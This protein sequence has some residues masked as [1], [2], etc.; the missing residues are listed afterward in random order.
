MKTKEN[1]LE[2]I[3]EIRK[4]MEG[5][6]RFL[7]L[8]GLSGVLVGIYAL[9]GAFMANSLLFSSGLFAWLNG[10]SLVSDLFILGSIVFGLSLLTIILL[11]FIRVKKSGK[12]FWNAGSRLMLVNLSIPIVSGGLLILVLV[13]REIYE[14]IIPGTLLFYGLA[15]VNAAK[16]TRQEIF[17]LGL[18][19][20]SLGVIAAI[21]P[22]FGLIIW[23][24][25]F[26]VLHIIYGIVMYYRYERTTK[27]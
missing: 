22:S 20:I 21:L 6:S 3:S 1:Y 25:G 11:T 9:A 24:V 16:F 10:D 27:K 15:L 14:I 5:S 7:T 19:Q 12:K 17:Y 13:Y 18:F 23:A 4:M 26:G 2:E 8:S